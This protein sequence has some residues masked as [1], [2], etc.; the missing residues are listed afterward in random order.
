MRSYLYLLGA[1]AFDEPTASRFEAA[2]SL[3]IALREQPLRPGC[4]EAVQQLERQLHMAPALASEHAWLFVLGNPTVVAHPYAAYWLEGQ[5][6]GESTLS[7]DR[8]MQAF[9]FSVAPDSGL[10]PDH[11]VSELEFLALLSEQDT[12]ES[13]AA[14]QSFVA[15]HMHHWVPRFIEAL[16]QADP[17]LHPFY[18][19]SVDLL[20]A[21]MACGLETRVPAQAVQRPFAPTILN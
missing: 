14:A 16:R 13:R 11:I 5:L 8:R 3:I 20:D 17:P 9:G 2:R 18:S 10:M 12:P 21:L 1:I 6:M 19:A 15:G 4:R 7:V